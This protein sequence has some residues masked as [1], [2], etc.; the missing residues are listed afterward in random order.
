[1]QCSIGM[2]VLVLDDDPLTAFT[3][4]RLFAVRGIQ[5]VS[6]STADAAERA[7]EAERFDALLVDA[8]ADPTG[9]ARLFARARELHPG[10]SLF[11]V[12]DRKQPAGRAGADIY[13]IEKPWDGFF[14]VD[15]VRAR[16]AG[17]P[18][19][20]GASGR[21]RSQDDRPTVNIRPIRSRRI[22]SDTA[23]H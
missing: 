19:T 6:V 10:I 15:I 13:Y 5:V 1:L 16:C 3:L 8:Q 12:S 9:G 23:A 18:I 21:L 20:A 14:V 2:R 4:L 17:E 22:S 11:L 7:V